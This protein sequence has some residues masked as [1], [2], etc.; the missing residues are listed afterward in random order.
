MLKMNFGFG[1]LHLSSKMKITTTFPFQVFEA[2]I[3]RG[4][5]ESC[6]FDFEFDFDSIFELEVGERFLF[7]ILRFQ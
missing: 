4:A 1:M 7:A 3:F 6:C 2:T 5:L